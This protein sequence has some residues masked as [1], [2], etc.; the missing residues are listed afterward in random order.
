MDTTDIGRLAYLV[1][2]A[3]AVGGYFIAQHRRN[4][5][6]LAQQAMVWALIFVGVIAGYGLWGDISRDLAPRQS[7]LESG[8]IEVPR[9]FDGHFYLTARLNGEP[10]DFVVDTGAT[11]VVLTMKDAARIGIDPDGLAFTGRA[12]TANGMVRTAPAT[13]DEI[14]LGDITDRNLRVFVNEGE[15]DQSLLGM[16]YLRRFSKIEIAG[17]MLVLTR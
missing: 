3:A 8:Q 4:W 14:R 11:D 13:V 9:M 2:L 6:K 5:S 12:F 17:D 1:L 15:M 16:A 10:V 7:V